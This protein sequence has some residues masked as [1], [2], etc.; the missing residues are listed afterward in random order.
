[1]TYAPSYEPQISK[2]DGGG[3]T[4]PSLFWARGSKHVAS[5][6]DSIDSDSFILPPPTHPRMW[7][8]EAPVPPTPDWG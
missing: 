3:D 2:L 8:N 1:M 6:G 4:L 7:E 5:L